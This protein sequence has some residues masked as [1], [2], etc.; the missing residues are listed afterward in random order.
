MPSEERTPASGRSPQPS[1]GSSPHWFTWRKAICV[2]LV[3]LLAGYVYARPTLESWLGVEL[4]AILESNPE[5]VEDSDTE[6]DAEDR[7]ASERPSADGN[8]DADESVESL[9]DG[10]AFSRTELSGGRFQTPAG[11]VYSPSRL[12]HVMRHARNDPQRDQR[13]GVFHADSE[14]AVLLVVDEVFRFATENPDSRR[15]DLE[16]QGERRVFTVD[17]NREIGYVG[18]RVGDGNGNPPCR[19]VRLVLAGNVVITAYPLRP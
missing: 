14:D 6:G 7:V 1:S 18:G 11:L 2:G 12:E 4:P 17:L 5:G 19:H 16:N 10:N 8:R 13:H 15:V 9:A 3:L